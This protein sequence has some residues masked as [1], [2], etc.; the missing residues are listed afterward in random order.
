MDCNTV[1]II[2]GTS[3]SLIKYGPSDSLLITE[4]LQTYKKKSGHTYIM[5]VNR[6]IQNFE[7]SKMYVPTFLK[8]KSKQN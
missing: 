6:W 3:K 8:I 5:F 4:I 1:F 2:L 7:K